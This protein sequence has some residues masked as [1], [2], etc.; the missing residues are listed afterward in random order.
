MNQ[1]AQTFAELATNTAGQLTSSYGEWTHFLE[2]AARLYKDV[3][4]KR[5]KGDFTQYSIAAGSFVV[6]PTICR[7]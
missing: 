6:K 4:C 7:F 5:W 1:K 3:C 2:T